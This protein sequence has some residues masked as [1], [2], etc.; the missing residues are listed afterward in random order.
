MKGIITVLI[1]LISPQVNGQEILYS[2]EKPIN[3]SKELKAWC[4]NKSSEYFLA[5]NKT[6]YNWTDSWWNEGG[7]L[8]VKGTWKVGTEEHIVKCRVRRGVAEKYA[9]WELVKK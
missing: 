6:P 8:F 9:A 7:F 2:E 1:L 5:Q 3:T 4:K